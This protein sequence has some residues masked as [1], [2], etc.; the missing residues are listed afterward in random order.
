[1]AT[2]DPWIE[3]L[4][5]MFRE[6]PAW[7]EAARMID[8]R[9]TST[10]Y[11]RHRPGDPWHLER[12]GDETLLEPGAADDP[13]L[14]FRFPPGAIDRLAAVRGSAGDFAAELFTLALSDD[15]DLCV[16]IRIAASFPRLVRRGYVRLLVAAGPRVR[17]I[18]AAHSVVGL[19]PLRRLVMEL[20]SRDRAKWEIPARSTPRGRAGARRH[21]AAHRP[22]GSRPGRA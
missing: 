22:T 7:R 17:A 15:P 13:D 9:S 5:R 3:R 12:R 2:T 20:R 18:G 14:V 4:A 6:H 11:F 10:V 8:P 21:R 16:K 19:T 1:M